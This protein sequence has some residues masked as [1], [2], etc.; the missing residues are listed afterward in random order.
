MTGGGRGVAL[1]P[2]HADS[3]HPDLDWLEAE[4]AGPRPPKMVVI[5][6][7]CN[8]TGEPLCNPQVVSRDARVEEGAVRHKLTCCASQGVSA[9]C[10]GGAAY[11]R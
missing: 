6:N 5:V 8:P 4:L 2:C 3:M 9:W 1:G 11:C 10:C 7:P